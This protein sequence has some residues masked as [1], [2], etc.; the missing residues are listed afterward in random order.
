MLQIIL[1]G[2]MLLYL[3]KPR[4]KSPIICCRQYR[5]ECLKSL[6]VDLLTELDFMDSFSKE[7]PKNYQI[8]YHRR[9]IVETLGDSS[10]EL[11]FTE[12]V[13]EIDS[14]NYH[15]WAHRYASF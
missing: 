14:K 13:F 10:R 5:R 11:A 12:E 1:F 3:L 6:G 8:W 2:E 15:A 7:N 9:A 4:L